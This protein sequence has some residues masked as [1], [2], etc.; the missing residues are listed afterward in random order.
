MPRISVS[1]IAPPVG[2]VKCLIV[3]GNMPFMQKHQSISKHRLTCVF[4]REISGGSS[5]LLAST[6]V[7]RGTRI[8]SKPTPSLSLPLCLCQ[9]LSISVFLHQ[10]PISASNIASPRCCYSCGLLFL[11]LTHAVSK[12]LTA[13]GGV[14]FSLPAAACQ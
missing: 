6:Y 4:V 10:P 7:P 2:A 12:V 11:V 13:V 8:L 14:P 1:S 9:Q 3:Y 5:R